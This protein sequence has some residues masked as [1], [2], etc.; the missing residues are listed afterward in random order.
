MFS[1]NNILPEHGI[2]VCL[3][4]R[5]SECVGEN[6]G[7]LE[8][9]ECILQFAK[10]RAAIDTLTIIAVAVDGEKYFWFDLLKAIDNALRAK[11]GRATGPDCAQAGRRE[12]GDDSFG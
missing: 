9:R 3:G 12:E 10:N 11:F 6:H 4:H 5:I 1:L 2:A 7:S 8:G